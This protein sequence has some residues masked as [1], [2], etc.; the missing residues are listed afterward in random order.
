MVSEPSRA[1]LFVDGEPVLSFVPIEHDGHPEAD[2]AVPMA[3]PDVVV[4]AVCRQLEDCWFRSPDDGLTDALIA[5][6]AT[7]VRHSH[8][9]TCDVTRTQRPRTGATVSIVPIGASSIEL[10]ELNVR[11]YPPDHVDFETNDATE[12]QEAIDAMLSGT[13]IGPFM[14]SASA[15]VT[16]AGRPVAVLIIN[17]MPDH[18]IAGGPWVTELFRDPDPAYRGPGARLLERAIR[19]LRSEGE[20]SLSLAVT[21]GNPALEVYRRS[22]FDL[23]ASRRKLLIPA[24]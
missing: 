12:A 15:M 8:V 5:G 9:M 4:P 16:D 23:V 24:T 2:D 21:E 13:L 20:T 3:E 11:A 1:Q 17:R 19:T 7:V 22:G 10:A 6:G 14:T 18:A